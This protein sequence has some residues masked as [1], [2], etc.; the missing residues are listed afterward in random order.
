MKTV[1]CWRGQVPP[2]LSLLTPLPFPTPPPFWLSLAL[3]F[4]VYPSSS[5][6]AAPAHTVVHTLFPGALRTV[7]FTLSQTGQGWGLEVG[8]WYQYLC[9]C[10]TSPFLIFK[11]GEAHSSRSQAKYIFFKGTIWKRKFQQQS[12]LTHVSKLYTLR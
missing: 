3:P 1:L 10:S 9:C 7:G 11:S 6:M 12:I 5:G 4:P 2:L 8:R